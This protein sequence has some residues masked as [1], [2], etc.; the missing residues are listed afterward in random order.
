MLRWD[1]GEAPL[2]DYGVVCK[3]S[4]QRYKVVLLLFSATLNPSTIIPING[5]SKQ[6]K[7]VFYVM[8]SQINIIQNLPVLFQLSFNTFS[9][10]HK[11][12]DPRPTLLFGDDFSTPQSCS[13]ECHC[14][15]Q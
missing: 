7:Y 13:E 15:S 9:S 1:F 2:V 3:A 14:L 11:H 12:R 8:F 6:Y 10:S 4:P 5:I